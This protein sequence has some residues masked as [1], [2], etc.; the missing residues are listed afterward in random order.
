ML[1]NFWYACA[2]SSEI[3]NKPK[4]I[5]MLKQK[6]VFYRDS[7]GKVI[8]LKDRCPHRGAAL[9]LG[10]VENGCIRCPYHGWKYQADGK[11]IDIPAN[12]SGVAIPKKARVDSYPVQEKY[13]FIWLFYG[14]LPEEQ[15]PPIPSLP[16][17]EDPTLHPIYYEFKVNAHY[18]RTLENAIDFAH[19]PI[20]HG[21]SFG[22][23][24]KL[25]QKIETYDLKITDWG[26]SAK[27]DLLKYHKQ[28]N[29]LKYFVRP[30][31]SKVESKISFYLPNINKLE[32]SSAEGKLVNFGT[33]IPIDDNTTIIKRIQFRSF[34]TYPWLD[35]LFKKSSFKANIEDKVVAESI[36]SP[37]LPANLSEEVHVASDILQ[38]TYRKLR[39]KY[40]TLNTGEQNKSD[41]YH[42]HRLKTTTTSVN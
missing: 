34:L 11:C 41:K 31:T 38:I 13:G 18:T 4:Q 7:Q 28:N 5:V 39:Q 10:W 25:D 9:S 6:F 12:E 8:A 2:F 24:F 30:S 3:T 23:G 33:H 17:L 35:F 14:D 36:Y 42:E 20:I 37:I 21:N 32:A 27:V 1:K 22:K 19:V 15:R 26:A 29:F 16:E 40:L